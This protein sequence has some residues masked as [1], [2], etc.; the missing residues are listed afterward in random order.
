MAYIDSQ[1]RFSNAQAVT[2]SAAST[3]VIDLG[4]VDSDWGPGTPLWIVVHC[5]TAMTDAGSNS[6]VA[7]TLESDT[8]DTFGSATTIQTLPTFAA[9]SAAGTVVMAALAPM[10]T[11]ERFIRVQYTVA[12]GD[13]TTGSFTA[14]ITTHAL[15][16]WTAV[17]DGITIS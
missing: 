12:N 8:V 16:N 5:T 3:N 13:L 14:Y 1:L 17:A 15:Q 4:A 10:A 7:P 11:N 9:L 6:T 2:A